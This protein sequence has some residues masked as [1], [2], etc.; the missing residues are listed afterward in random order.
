MV[1]NVSF[2]SM[3]FKLSWFEKNAV[4]D[5]TINCPV[6]KVNKSVLSRKKVFRKKIYRF[7]K[8]EY[9]DLVSFA[10]ILLPRDAFILKIAEMILYC[11]DMLRV[12]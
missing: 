3:G 11:Y 1:N 10:L 8:Y 6:I 9:F 7:M 5:T 12:K 4:F 2:A